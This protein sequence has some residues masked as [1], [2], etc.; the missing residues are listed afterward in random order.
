MKH[1]IE[2]RKNAVVTVEMG[3]TSTACRIQYGVQCPATVRCY[4]AYRHERYI[5]VAD[6][7]VK[8]GTL[9]GVPCA[10]FLFIDLMD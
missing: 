6:V 10:C 4:V 8:E 7:E 3:G 1:L 5:E 2:F 9:R